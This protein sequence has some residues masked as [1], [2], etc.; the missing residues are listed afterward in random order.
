MRTALIIALFLL[1]MPLQGAFGAD[2]VS[3]ARK[4]LGH[5]ETGSDNK[6]KYVRLYTNG[7]E[8]SWCAGFVSYVLK[9]SGNNQFGYILSAKA[10]WN[11]AKKMKLTTKTPKKGYLIVF[12]RD[13]P[14]S[15]KGHIGIVEK[16]EGDIITTIEG[17]TGN[18]P[19]V[20][21]RKKY[22]IKKIDKLLGYI[23][24]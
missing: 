23:K 7:I 9:K 5:G 13:N 6:G 17:N 20:V 3:E 21:K 19:S 1:W 11:K 8:S 4:E 24:I 18:F 15:W 14:Q 10:Y 22:N 16:V 12:W 2:I